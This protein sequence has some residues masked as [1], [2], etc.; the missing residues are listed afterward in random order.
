MEKRMI[1]KKDVLIIL[2]MAMIQ[3]ALSVW[4]FGTIIGDVIVGDTS[5][6]PIVVRIIKTVILIPYAPVFF[7]INQFDHIELSA[8]FVIMAL[9][10]LAFN[11]VIYFILRK[12][13]WT[14]KNRCK[15]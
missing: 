7:M 11:T 8:I 10:T 12:I 9:Y 14:I 2:T 13:T 6:D 15:R 4:A 5:P 1:R 3:I